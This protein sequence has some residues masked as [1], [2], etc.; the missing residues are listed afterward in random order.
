MEI[1]N[2]PSNHPKF[3]GFVNSGNKIFLIQLE[4]MFSPK[5]IFGF[6]K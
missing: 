4:E 1:D 6:K 5:A 2:N 3:H